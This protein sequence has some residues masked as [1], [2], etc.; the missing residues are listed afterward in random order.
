MLL[1][2][3][4]KDIVNAI[5][6]G[7]VNNIQTFIEQFCQENLNSSGVSFFRIGETPYHY[8][9]NHYDDIVSKVRIYISLLKVLEMNNFIFLIP[10][11]SPGYSGVTNEI[12][13]H[14]SNNLNSR[15]VPYMA[16]LNEFIQRK[17]LTNQEVAYEEEK[18]DRK[19]SQRLTLVVAIGSLVLTSLLNY[20]SYT[21][22]RSVTIKNPKDTVFV[23]VVSPNIQSKTSDKPYTSK[24]KVDNIKKK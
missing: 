14:L 20:F 24:T 17:W 12:I 18:N 21:T 5:N 9:E 3:L 23:K 4:Q 8:D 13:T 2:Q 19:K 11:P 7:R 10:A 22:D 1:T 16:E 6:D 15:I